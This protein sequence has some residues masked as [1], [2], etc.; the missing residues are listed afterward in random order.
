MTAETAM[1]THTYDSSY[2]PHLALIRFPMRTPA[3]AR[4][5]FGAT[6]ADAKAFVLETTCTECATEACS[7]TSCGDCGAPTCACHTDPHDDD[8]WFCADCQPPA[9]LGRCCDDDRDRW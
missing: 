9:C 4:E 8:R 1:V 3:E 6:L 7:T 5:E 2:R